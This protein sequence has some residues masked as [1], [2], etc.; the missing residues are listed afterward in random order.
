[1]L[2]LGVRGLSERR[3]VTDTYCLNHRTRS[4]LLFNESTSAQFFF[5]PERSELV[6]FVGVTLIDALFCQVKRSSIK[7]QVKFIPKKV[8]E[9]FGKI[10]THFLYF[11][12]VLTASLIIGRTHL[13]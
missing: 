12:F 7:F 6:R 5:R 3:C 1:M 9:L 11:A 13:S 4:D 2:V 8:S 10:H